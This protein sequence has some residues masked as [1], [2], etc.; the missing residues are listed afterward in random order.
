M[1][2]EFDNFIS[3]GFRLDEDKAI[4]KQIK[5]IARNNNMSFRDLA[6]IFYNILQDVAYD[7]P[8]SI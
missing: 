2:N 6:R 7:N 4:E 8:I 1:I 3:I 5:E